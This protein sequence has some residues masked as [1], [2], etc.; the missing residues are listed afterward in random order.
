VLVHCVA[1]QTDYLVAH[2]FLARRAEMYIDLVNGLADTLQKVRP[3]AVGDGYLNRVV[4][5]FFVG[6]HKILLSGL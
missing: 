6:V 4:G 1:E 3:F 5:R 2:G